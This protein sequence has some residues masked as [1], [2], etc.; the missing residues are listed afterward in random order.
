MIDYFLLSLFVVAIAAGWFLGR[1]SRRRLGLSFDRALPSQYYRGL[2]FLLDGQQDGA[3]DAFT[4]ALEVNTETFDTHVALGNVLRRRGE[5]ERAIRIHQNLLARPSLPAAQLHLAHLEL[6][7]DYISAGLL[8]RA[9]RLLLDLVGESGEHRRIARRYLLE[10]YE[11]QK[12]WPQAREVAESLLLKKPRLLKGLAAKEVGQPVPT[13]LAHYCCEQAQQLL[14]VGE[15]AAARILLNEALGHD[16]MCPRA[17]IMMGQLELQ[18]GRPRA[19]LKALLA[20]KNQDADFVPDTIQLLRSTYLALDNRAALRRYLE[21]CFADRP[22]T[23][24]VLEIA[25]EIR[26]TEGDV[27]AKRFLRE[28]LQAKP[29]LRGLAMLMT[30]HSE[31]E[32]GEDERLQIDTLQR[33]VEQRSHYRCTHCGFRGRQLYWYC[34]GCKHW[35]TIRDL[36]TTGELLRA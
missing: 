7:R 20:V 22:S 19:A 1:R 8:D 6:A 13:L 4:Q 16:A 3:I 15:A 29:S 18:E 17:S 2:N 24:L 14:E 12:D 5:V 31:R 36:G 32:A 9:E 25:A 35:G 11:A 10:I 30:L 21:A 28:S 27:A 34:P 33:L 26:D 23:T